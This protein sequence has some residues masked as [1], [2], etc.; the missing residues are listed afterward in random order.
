MPMSFTYTAKDAVG[1]VRKGV[2]TAEDEQ[3]FLAKIREKGMYVTDYKERQSSTKTIKKFKTKDLAFCTRQMAAMLTSGLTLVKA[4]DI[5]CKEQESEAARNVWRDVYENV[6]KGEAFSDALEVHGSVFPTLMT[7]MVGAGESSGQMDVIMQRLSDYYANQNKI[8]NTIKSAMVYPIILMVL[9]VAVVIGVFVF[10]MPVFTD[11]YDDPNDIPGLTKVMIAIGNFLTKHWLIMILLTAALI[12]T[13]IYLL[14]LPNTRMKWDRFIIKGPGFGKL[15]VKIYTAR[16]AQTMASLY[17]SGLP[18]VE[19][20]K[21]SADT[22][23]N[24]YISMKFRDI[25]DEVKSGETLSSSIQ[26]AD[27]FDSM[28]CSIIFVGE[29]SGALDDILA[30]TAEYYDEEADSA[31]KR[32]CSLLEPVMLIVLGI[33]IGLVCA[34][35]FPALYDSIGNLGDQ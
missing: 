7:S 1:N 31:V 13:F 22:L 3:E 12:F 17:S 11:L 19:C 2:M 5:L 8:A 32:L 26:R 29:E 27:I 33:V 24:T 16:F 10:I 18:M 15:V 21:R 23:N 28:F 20:L 9:T 25:I 6:Q 35:F 34:A 4:L 30:K 14:K